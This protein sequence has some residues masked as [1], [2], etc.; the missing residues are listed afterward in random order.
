MAMAKA[1]KPTK[2]QIAQAKARAGGS[3]AIIS[4]AKPTPKATVKPPVKKKVVVMHGY[5]WMV[6]PS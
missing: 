4:K 1:M 5:N 6:N 3:T 2:Q